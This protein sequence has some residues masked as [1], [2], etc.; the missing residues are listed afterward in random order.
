MGQPAAKQGDQIIAVDTHIVITPSGT[1]T[2]LPHPFSGIINGN[3]SSDINI[4]GMPAATVDSTA[5]NTPP[6][7]PTPPGTGFQNPPA[8]KG[9][10]KIGSPTVNIN[11]KS[12]ARN[13]DTAET[14]NDPVDTPVGQVVAVSTVFIG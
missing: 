10:V 11:G 13:G 7:I 14:C 2:P 1:P 4:M 3:L 6:H 5:D 9:T 12:A 8:N